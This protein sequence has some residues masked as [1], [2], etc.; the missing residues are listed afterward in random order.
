MRL[1][2]LGPAGAGKGTQ[3]ELLAARYGIPHVS[4]G[5]ILRAAVANDSEVGLKAHSFM[6]AGS[7]VPDEAV[8]DVMREWLCSDDAKA[9][10]VLDGFPRTVPQAEAFEKI[11]EDSPPVLD[12]VILVDVPDS[13]ILERLSVRWSCPTCGAVYSA[14]AQNRPLNVGY[15]NRDGSSLRQREDD[16]P[17]V[18]RHRLEVYRHQTAPLIGYYESRGFLRRVDGIGTPEEVHERVMKEIS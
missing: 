11:L 18:I 10:Y 6:E 5:D 12:A 3:A 7:L 9:G 13:A 17:E 8:L 14:A 16:N 1:I 2:L 15:C 4:T